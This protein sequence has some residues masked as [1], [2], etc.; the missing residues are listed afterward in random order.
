MDPNS[1]EKVLNFVQR[2]D[3]YSIGAIFI[4]MGFLYTT[5]TKFKITTDKVKIEPIDPENTDSIFNFGIKLIEVGT[6]ICLGIYLGNLIAMFIPTLLTFVHTYLM[7]NITPQSTY[8]PSAT[9][10]NSLTLI[11]VDNVLSS[12][13]IITVSLK[14]PFSYCSSVVFN[15]MD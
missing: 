6:V 4:F 13:E 1:I 3:V 11:S 15:L 12:K 8:L 2:Y 7:L 14:I 9:M 10:N 5:A